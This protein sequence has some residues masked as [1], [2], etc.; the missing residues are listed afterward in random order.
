VSSANY[1]I[2]S[3]AGRKKSSAK[4]N[5]KGAAGQKFSEQTGKSKQKNS[6]MD[7]CNPF[8]FERRF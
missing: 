6:R 2:L 4:D 5:I 1:L 8:A 3:A 7:L